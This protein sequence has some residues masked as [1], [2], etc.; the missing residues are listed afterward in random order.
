MCFGPFIT[1]AIG[2]VVLLFQA[3]LLAH[4]GLSTLGA[5]MVSMAIGGPLVG[6]AVYKFLKNT[7]VNIYV[8]VFCVAA[9][10]DIVTYVI[11]SF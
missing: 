11:T 8:T 3:L 1:A 7:S 6:Y 2:F 10:A 5:N 9:V 4:G